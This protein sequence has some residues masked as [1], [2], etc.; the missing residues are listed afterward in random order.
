MNIFKRLFGKKQTTVKPPKLYISEVE[1]DSIVNHCF[2]TYFYPN[3]EHFDSDT[4]YWQ[5]V[6]KAICYAE[7]NFNMIST[8]WEKDL[9]KNGYDKVTGMKYLSEGLM[10][11]SY[12]DAKY[13]N[14]DFDLAIDRKK[15]EYDQ[16]KTIFNPLKNISCG[17]NILDKM[18]GKNGGYIFNTNNYWAVLKP[19]NKRHK[20]FLEKLREYE[21]G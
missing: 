4:K 19:N 16:T 13:Y 17:L 14:C 2:N 7:S 8:F 5:N 3:L 20:V 15:D 11:L 10:Q 1:I 21:N 18:V 6:V 9:G 12:S